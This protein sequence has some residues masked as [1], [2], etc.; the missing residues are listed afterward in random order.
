LWQLSN[1]GFFFLI[2]LF[3]FPAFFL[4]PVVTGIL[5]FVLRRSKHS[6]WLHGAV[7]YGSAAMLSF[8]C[9]FALGGVCASK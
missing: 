9:I 6:S 8:W 5:L 1:E 4:T 2:A 3:G 7:F